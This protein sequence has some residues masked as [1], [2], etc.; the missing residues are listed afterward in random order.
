MSKDFDKIKVVG[1]QKVHELT[2]IPLVYVQAILNR[3][4]ED[5]TRIQLNGFISILEREYF[6]NL[7]ELREDSS[8][9]FNELAPK[10]TEISNVIL[11]SKQKSSK[12]FYYT[13]LIIGV[14]IGVIYFSSSS[15]SQKDTDS[16]DIDESLITSAQANMKTLKDNAKAQEVVQKVVQE[17]AQEVIQEKVPAVIQ[18]VAQEKIL[19]KEQKVIVPKIKEEIVKKEETIINPIVQKKQ[20][21]TKYFVIQPKSNLWLGYKDL[22]T[23]R[24]YQMTTEEDI[25]LDSKKTWLLSCGHGYIK[26]IINGKTIEFNKK[27]TMRFLYKN[28]QIKRIYFRKYQEL[29]AGG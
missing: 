24:S 5:M 13:V 8:K 21:N 12:A 10:N 18:D 17:K 6:L 23:G 11:S 15:S 19:E 29:N 16:Q 3:T 27:N 2:H 14:F 4:Y 7:D 26:I 20:I 9:Y 25:Q 28:G 22:D 1:A